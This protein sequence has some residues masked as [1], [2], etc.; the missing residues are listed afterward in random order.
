MHSNLFYF[1]YPPPAPGFSRHWRDDLVSCIRLSYTIP[2]IDQADRLRENRTSL[3]FYS[4][5]FVRLRVGR[6]HSCCCFFW[7][8][9]DRVTL[10]PLGSSGV[11]LWWYFLGRRFWKWGRGQK[12]K[13]DGILCAQ[14]VG[15][16]IRGSYFL[17]NNPSSI[18]KEG[19]EFC[20][21]ILVQ[22]SLVCPVEIGH[23]YLTYLCTY[24]RCVFAA[25]E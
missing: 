2:L 24:Q 5:F 6:N 19:I 14:V 1:K 3:P 10:V 17:R 9:G 13:R 18:Y 4:I 22:P 16:R 23:L 20:F 12:K 25:T 15:V 8:L 11:L 21:A 7:E